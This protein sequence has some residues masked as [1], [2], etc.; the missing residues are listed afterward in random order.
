MTT[1]TTGTTGST[2]HDV[3]T[4]LVRVVSHGGWGELVLAN[5]DRRNALVPEIAAG[6]ADGLE[7]LEVDG[8]AALVIRG[9]GATF[10]AGLDLA[11]VAEG[12]PPAMR[13]QWA[14]L[15]RRLYR[16]GIVTIAALEGWAVNAGAALALACD[17]LVA[18][19]GPGCA[20]PRWQWGCGHR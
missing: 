11:M 17:L 16:T 3:G 18:G 8:C 20:S 9:E 6:L 14:D 2:T 1:G 10:C 19:R 13:E 7:R 5:P 4:P 15:H 12:V